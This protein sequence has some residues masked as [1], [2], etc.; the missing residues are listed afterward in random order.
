[1]VHQTFSWCRGNDGFFL[2][3]F[4][5]GETTAF[6]VF[7]LG[8]GEGEALFYLLLGVEVI[9]FTTFVLVYGKRWPF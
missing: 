7:L 8:E 4:G 9:A 6:D 1:M 5:V 3:L 2:Y